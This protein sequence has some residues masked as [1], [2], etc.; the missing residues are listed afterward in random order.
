VT[1][2]LGIPG[3]LRQGSFNRLLLRAIFEKTPAG[4]E[5]E[6][7]SLGGIPL[8]DGD[9]EQSDFPPAV[10]ALKDKIAAADGV[11]LA[12]PEYNYS[13]PGVVKNAIDWASRPP[14]DG[15]WRNKAVAIVGASSGR[16]GTVRG[17]QHLRLVFF[18]VGALVLG[19]PEILVGPAGSVFDPQGRLLDSRLEEQIGKWWPAFLAWIDRIDHWAPLESR[20]RLAGSQ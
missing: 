16:F 7:F 8:Y 9:V 14:A 2:I 15:A 11:I 5:C 13:I 12:S 10:Q 18:S 3:S 20:G 17:Q 19:Q 4:V 1:R 6:V